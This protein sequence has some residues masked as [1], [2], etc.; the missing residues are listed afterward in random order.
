[1]ILITFAQLHTA[2][3]DDSE[4]EFADG[5]SDELSGVDEGEDKGDEW[6][7]FSSDFDLEAPEGSRKSEGSETAAHCELLSK[8]Y[9]RHPN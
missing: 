2:E 8:S 9:S 7:G 4:S 5:G 3:T 1:M 6:A